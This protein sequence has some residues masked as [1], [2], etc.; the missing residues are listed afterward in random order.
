AGRTSLQGT[1]LRSSRSLLLATET[2]LA[3]V[4]LVGSGLLIRS[5][6]ELQH[7]ET[8]IEADNVLSVHLSLPYS[9]YPQGQQ[10]VA[11]FERLQ[12]NVEDLGSVDSAALVSQI[13]LTYWNNGLFFSIEGEPVEDLSRRPGAHFQVVSPGYF[14]TMGIPML[15]GRDF[16]PR[17]REGAPLA[18]IV[19]QALVDSH[20]LSGDPI[21]RRITAGSADSLR[22]FEIVGVIGNVRVQGLSPTAQTYLPEIYVPLAQAPNNSSYLVLRAKPGQ[23]D[24]LALTPV[25]REQ[26]SR[27]D[28]QQPVTQVR[29]MREVAAASLS[30]E[31]FITLLLGAF[32]L[33]AV[34]LASVGIYSVVAFVVS[35]LTHQ[36]GI[37]RALGAL[38]RHVAALVLRQGLRPAL[39]GILAGALL[40]VGLG[41]LIT[42]LL[43]QVNP[44]DPLILVGSAL[45]LTVT[46]LL[47]LAVPGRRASRVQPAVA[48]RA[49]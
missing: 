35:R 37:R 28:P 39:W 38:N 20:I 24:P 32:A 9:K 40:A 6:W 48:L 44:G 26:V 17:D 10:V 16:N 4:L 47:A 8:G 30:D 12:S 29:S 23:G 25:L 31:R 49:E 7:S 34:F 45:L 19:N 33:T 13:P 46:T 2:A 15:Q 21:G 22:T 14:R 36:I 27:I 5:L 11:F 42:S 3:L 41:E 1:R 43:Y 18:A